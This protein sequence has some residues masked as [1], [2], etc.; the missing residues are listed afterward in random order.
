MTL[1]PIH[2]MVYFSPLGPPI[3]SALGLVDRQQYFAPRS[4]PLGAVSAEVVASTF[5]NFSR[6]LVQTA[7][8][9]CWDIA[10]PAEI[11]RAR[12]EVVD[13]S[14]QQ[15]GRAAM[16]G[17][18]IGRAAEIARSAAMTACECPEG[19]PLFAGHV[20]LPW[21]SEAHLMLW[22]AQTLLRE[23]RG[24]GHIA[25]LLNENLSGLEALLTHAATGVI[26]E[27]LMQKLR[28]YSNEEW[29]AG[30][31]SLRRRGILHPTEFTLSEFGEAMRQRIEDRT[32]TLAFEP[33]ARL[34][35]E[36]CAELRR[37]ARPLSAALVDAGWSPLRRLPP[38][39]DTATR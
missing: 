39:E 19:R 4:A 9:S 18:G 14:L 29:E 26:P 3:Y 15:A 25:V 34:G 32:D 24:D 27:E 13:Q 38:P 20:D 16:V 35:E 7:V 33:Y 31:E 5:F 8:P 12:Y 10:S 37:L 21:P 36:R 28:G 17:D 30:K 2:G 11:L 23:F 1:E 6:S 22:H